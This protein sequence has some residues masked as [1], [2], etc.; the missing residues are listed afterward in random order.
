MMD[1]SEH[2]VECT[3]ETKSIEDIENSITNSLLAASN[4][5]NAFNCDKNYCCRTFCFILALIFL[6]ILI[7]IIF[8]KFLV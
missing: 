2:S 3:K 6:A 8:I 1:S 4:T 5:D 7:T